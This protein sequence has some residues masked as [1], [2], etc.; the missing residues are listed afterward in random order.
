MELGQLLEF[1]VHRAELGVRFSAA[2]HRACSGT[3][4]FA[5]FFKVSGLFLRGHGLCEFTP[6]FQFSVGFMLAEPV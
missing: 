1:F 3:R 2:V 6:E 5:A 4:F